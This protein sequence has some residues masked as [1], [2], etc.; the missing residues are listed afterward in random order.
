M[1][2][3]I[4]RAKLLDGLARNCSTTDLG[5]NENWSEDVL[6]MCFNYWVPEAQSE[7]K[8]RSAVETPTAYRVSMYGGNRLPSHKK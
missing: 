5:I 3:A 8:I 7:G 4:G 2:L 1:I 6:A